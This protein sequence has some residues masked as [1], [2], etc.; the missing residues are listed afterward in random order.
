MK[1][2]SINR[3][4][5][6][7]LITLL[8]GAIA[9]PEIAQAQQQQRDDEII[10]R[11]V[12]RNR[13]HSVWNTLE[14]SP[15][16]GLSLV[17]RMTQQYNVQLGVGFNFTEEWG[18]D[19]RGGYALG[20][21]TSVGT[22][23][24]ERRQGTTEVEPVDEFKDLWRMTWQALL[25]PRWSPIYGKLNIVTELPIHFQAYVTAGGGMVGLESESI[26]YCQ[27]GGGGSCDGFLKEE[28]Q[29]FAIA[30]GLGFRFFVAQGIGLRLE[31]LDMMYPDQYRRQIDMEAAAAEAPGSEPGEG[32]LTDSGLTNVLFFN[33]G[34]TLNF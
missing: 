10:D 18:L 15:T 17:N 3:S 25:M 12:V 30:A 14:L 8:G 22:S 21:L 34:A 23:A 24:R 9:T 27:G 6:P 4:L 28:R 32:T 11:V 33:V 13:K 20:D 5:L 2:R 1:R 16:F 7:L 19:V 29:S 31:L 26:V